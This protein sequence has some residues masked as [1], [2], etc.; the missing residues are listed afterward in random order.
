VLAQMEAR[1][2]ELAARHR[3]ETRFFGG[4]RYAARA[5]G[6]L[7]S[8]WNA[9]EESGVSAPLP[10]SRPA[11]RL[12]RGSSAAEPALEDPEG[13][14]SL[15]GVDASRIH[16]EWQLTNTLWALEQRA[17]ALTILLLT[18]PLLALLWL[19]VRW[20]S[21]A[22]FLFKQRRP[23]FMGRPF[24]IYKITTMRAGSD[25]VKTF[26][27]GVSLHDPAVTRI[28]RFLRDTKLDELPQLWNV[29]RGDMEFV[30]PRPI[31]PGLDQLLSEK[32]PG[33]NNRYLVKPGLTNIAQLCV[34]DNALGERAIEDW[35]TRFEG[36]EHYIR[37]KSVSYDLIL[38]AMTVLFVLM[39][40]MRSFGEPKADRPE[41]PPVPVDAAGMEERR[42]KR[43]G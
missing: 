33:F 24:T 12:L 41:P 3:Q 17:L 32:I 16:R 11:F 7:L 38:M 20:S 23:G 27:R 10:A 25:R 6:S 2:D 9:R 4:V 13:L 34:L 14:L 21:R 19:P 36:E 30:G 43:A 28:G 5:I 29:V 35:R 18:L 15:D 26:E 40:S 42:T 22:P 1:L 8:S 31:A 37:N 39:K